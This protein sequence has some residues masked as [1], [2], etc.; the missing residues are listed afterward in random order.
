MMD[1]EQAE[2]TIRAYDALVETVW[3]AACSYFDRNEPRLAE[4]NAVRVEIDGESVNVAYLNDSDWDSPTWTSF[5]VPL[6][7]VLASPEAQKEY[8]AERKAK[9]RAEAEAKA[10]AD[11]ALTLERERREYER[12][13]AKFG[14]SDTTP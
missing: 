4:D 14:A 10:R 6:W 7:Y 13:K 2:A 9:A 3:S 12:L 5:V 8:L 1:R 11:H